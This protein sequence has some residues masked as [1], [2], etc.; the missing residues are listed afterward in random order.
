MQ[1]L[2]IIPERLGAL[3][4]LAGQREVFLEDLREEFRRDLQN[5]IVGATVSSRNGKV[6]IGNNLYKQWLA[7]IKNKGFDYEI[8]FK[9]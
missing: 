7:K 2:A 3:T 6:V 5:F 4:Q 8:D 1:N 9:A